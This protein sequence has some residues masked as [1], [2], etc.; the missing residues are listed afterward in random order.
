AFEGTLRLRTDR[1]RLRLAVLEQD[2]VWDR[3]DA[4]PFCKALLLVVVDLDELEVVIRGDSVQHGCDRMARHA[5]LRPEVDEHRSTALQ[6]LLLERRLIHCLS[7][8]RGS[9]RLSLFQARMFPGMTSVHCRL[10]SP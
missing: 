1:L 8:D 2:H 7:H 9:F 5:P 6:D 3:E 10:V 4:V